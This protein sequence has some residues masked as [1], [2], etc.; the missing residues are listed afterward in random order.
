MHKKIARVS[1]SAALLLGAVFG[2]VPA[3]ADD[4]PQVPA[5]ATTAARPAKA[6]LDREVLKR[7]RS[8]LA[9]GRQ[10]D[11]KGQLA[12]A[13]KHF[14]A[15]VALVPEGGAAQSE[16]GWA[17]YRQKDL[18]VAER[19]TLAAIGSSNQPNLRAASLYN[20]GKIL[21]AQGKKAEAAK[22][23]RQS[24]ELSQN[25]VTLAEL[26]ALDPAAAAMAWPSFQALEGP[27]QIA[28]KTPAALLLAACRDQ[29]NAVVSTEDPESRVVSSEELRTFDAEKLDC[30][31]QSAEI[32]GAG[33]SIRVMAVSTHLQLNH[34]QLTTVAVWAKL[35]EGWFR[36]VISAATEWK[37]EGESTS[38]R[39]ALK[40][41]NYVE[42]RT[43]LETRNE[44]QSAVYFKGGSE[45]GA[46]PPET[47]YGNERMAYYVGIGASGRPSVSSPISFF[48]S[49]KV[50]EHSGAER[51]AQ[52]TYSLSLQADGTLKI[53]VPEIVRKRMSEKEF[54]GRE[55]LTP[56]GSFPLQFP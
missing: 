47:I 13:R 26:K 2:I 15:A 41:G 24:W 12:E 14:E 45:R 21:S 46:P 44:T 56:S 5:P 3:A 8:E 11:E 52:K 42:I 43:L 40:V 28:G 17:A 20:L 1:G 54:S 22:A 27:V 49:R 19:A 30:K 55:I 37:W 48:S 10:A 32:P 25:P 31:E 38:L 36:K 50:E 16:L 53:G 6:P 34:Y 35:R 29:I 33:A 18:A 39:S 9:Q 23:L 51:M 4:K 7:Y